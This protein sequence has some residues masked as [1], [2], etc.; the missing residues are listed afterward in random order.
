MLSR[1]LFILLVITSLL[2]SPLALADMS[3]QPRA[4]SDGSLVVGIFPRRNA[5]IT[6]RLFKPIADYLSTALNRKVSLV[7]AKDFP[8]FWQSVE[9]QQYDL[10]HYNQYHYVVSH[11][12]HGYQV[13]LKNQEVGKDEIS[14]VIT[15]R[16]DSDIQSVADL[17]GKKIAFGGGK[18]AM[19]SYIA[20]THLLRQHGLQAGDYIEVFARNPPNAIF[21][22]FYKQTAAAGSGD[23]IFRMG[24]VQKKVNVDELR[25]LAKGEAIA[26][27]PWAVKKD[28]SDR[29]REQIQTAML[30][31]NKDKP[32]LLAEALLTGLS[33]AVDADFDKHRAI[34]KSVLNENY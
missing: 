4:H 28:M 30:A 24:M 8:S 13:I 1:S 31:L 34:I 7:T 18:R 33:P 15:V 3:S 21:S 23:M 19:V 14:S 25:F 12:K 22:C 17:R 10:V 26:H 29:L 2:S 27:L 6:V 9:T 11:A 20:T 32:H 5:A 16:K